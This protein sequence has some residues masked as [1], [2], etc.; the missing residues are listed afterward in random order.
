MHIRREL[1]GVSHSLAQLGRVQTCTNV[2][3]GSGPDEIRLVCNQDD[4]P[5]T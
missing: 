1:N 2:W 3:I 4:T 5:I